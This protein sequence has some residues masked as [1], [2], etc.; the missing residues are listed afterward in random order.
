VDAANLLGNGHFRVARVSERREQPELL[1]GFGNR[2]LRH[3]PAARPPETHEVVLGKIRDAQA[4]RSPR[5][6]GA[7]VNEFGGLRL[8]DAIVKATRIYSLNQAPPTFAS[9]PLPP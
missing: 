9:P 6:K 8:A 3:R 2:S 4:H 1:L 5:V 7:C